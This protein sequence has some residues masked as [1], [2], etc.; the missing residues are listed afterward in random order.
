MKS[1]QQQQSYDKFHEHTQPQVQPMYNKHTN[2]HTK[3]WSTR[4]IIIHA[5][6]KLHKK[7]MKNQYLYECHGTLGNR[8]KAS[9]HVS[10][11]SF[12]L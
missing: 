6:S 7:F 2:S 5:W 4:K 3:S 9:L 8:V 1:Q 10:M 11:K 12:N